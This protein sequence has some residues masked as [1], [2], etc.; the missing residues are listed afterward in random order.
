MSHIQALTLHHFN[1][2][3]TPE[4]FVWRQARKLPHE[5][6]SPTLTD[7]FLD[8]VDAE[9]RSFIQEIG[10][11]SEILSYDMRENVPV[12][13]IVDDIEHINFEDYHDLSP[14][15]VNEA[16]MKMRDWRKYQHGSTEDEWDNIRFM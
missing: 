1:M 10:G 7:N 16:N 14:E 11:H 5:V 12:E 2:A 15:G 9:Y 6:N 8:S 4:R 13:H 3:V